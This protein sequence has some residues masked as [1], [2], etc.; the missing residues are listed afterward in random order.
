MRGISKK[1]L[2]V[3]MICISVLGFL[4]SIFLLFQIWYYHQPIT[5]SLQSGL[6]QSSAILQTTGEG[7]IVIDQVVK[8]VYTT[9]V[10][11]D[12]ATSALAQTMRSTSQ[13]MD[14]AST[15]I[16]E[17]LINTITNTQTALNSAQSSAVVI[18]NILST[19]SN[20][21][22]VGIKYNPTTPLNKALGE[23]ST[24]LDPIQASLK[25]F[26]TNL[27]NTNTNMQILNNQISTLDQKIV[28][29]NS[30]LLQA[31]T[32]ITSYRSQVNSLK[33]SVEMAK[34]NLPTW[35]QTISWIAT[36]I[37]LWLVLIQIGILLQGITLL[38]PFHLDPELPG[39]NQPNPQKPD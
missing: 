4:F 31:Q 11:L 8:N 6:E 33:S 20:I 38:S 9:T 30:N 26:Q 12:D 10:Y 16:G 39:E 34:I 23:V 32:T 5:D 28:T 17:D 18:D 37:I 22:L 29:I 19:I 35:I 7:L 13:F 3:I 36:V 21:P 14:S 25:N 1:A 27:D 15:F 24:S 2:G